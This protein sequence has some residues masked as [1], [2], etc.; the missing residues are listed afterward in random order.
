M[1]QKHLLF[2]NEGVTGP[3]V[4]V[5]ATGSVDGQCNSPFPME[6]EQQPIYIT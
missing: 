6:Q 4:L 1:A 3:L 5:F 2:S